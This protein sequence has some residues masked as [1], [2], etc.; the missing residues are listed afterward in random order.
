MKYLWLVF[1][2]CVC[3][4]SGTD[5]DA[6]QEISLEAQMLSGEALV[7]Y[8]KMNQNLFEVKSDPTPDFELKLMDIKFEKQVPNPVLKDNPERG[9]DIPENYDLRAIWPN[10]SSLFT[11]RDQANCGSCWAVSTASAISDRICIATKGEKQVY[12][13]ASDIV[14]CC[15]TQ[16]GSGCNGGWAYKAWEYF[17]EDGIVSGGHYH[18]KGCCRPYPLHP[19]GHH[20]NDTYYG[21]CP[22]K[23]KTPA[24]KRRCQPGFRKPY[25]LDKLYGKDV[26]LLPK[27]IKAIQRDIMENGPVVASFKVYEDFRHYKSGIYKHIAG[28]LQGYHAVKMIGW[29]KEN[30]TDYWLIANSWHD[31]WGE[32]GF[33]RTLRGSN[34]CGIEAIVCA[35]LV[36]VNSL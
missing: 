17:V 16:C 5:E 34:H 27:S 32:K 15:T 23:A 26:Y 20:G 1:C 25:R 29:G 33:F 12:I 14:T 24:C 22:E 6:A 18:S 30:G 9:D 28:Q 8:L 7:E 2:F 4:A 13:S 19:C 35:G 11:I 36:D 10:C 3:R 31:D 21:E